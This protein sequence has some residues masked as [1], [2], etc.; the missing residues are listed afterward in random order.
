[1]MEP[2]QPTPTPQAANQQPSRDDLVRIPW[3]KLLALLGSASD[4]EKFVGTVF[5]ASCSSASSFFFFSCS[6]YSVVS[7]LVFPPAL[8][9]FT[10]F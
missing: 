5:T 6:S 7:L 1:M 4:E 8:V 9:L 10:P 3:P 2:P